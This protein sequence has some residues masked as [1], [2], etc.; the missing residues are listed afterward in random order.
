VRP[1]QSAGFDLGR[2][3]DSDFG[4]SRNVTSVLEM[5]EDLDRSANAKLN[6][7]TIR[8]IDRCAGPA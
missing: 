4:D 5:F 6:G 1:K 3:N 7:T 2:T 8:F